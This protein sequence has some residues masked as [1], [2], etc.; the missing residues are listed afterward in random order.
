MLLPRAPGHR[1]PSSHQ[2]KGRRTWSMALGRCKPLSS[3][4]HC[5]CYVH[6]P[7]RET[8][9]NETEGACPHRAHVLIGLVSPLTQS[10]KPKFHASA[11]FS[12]RISIPSQNLNQ[13]RHL[14]QCILPQYLLDLSS[15]WHLPP[16]PPQQPSGW[17]CLLCWLSSVSVPHSQQSHPD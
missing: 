14:V 17:S 9:W 7:V 2:E 4:F 1:L 11:H 10:P 12:R 6:G 15:P 13:V 3:P 8:V 5:P 16:G